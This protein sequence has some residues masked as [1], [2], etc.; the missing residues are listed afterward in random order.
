MQTTRL[1]RTGLMVSRT[2][3]GALPIQRVDFETARA[4]LTRA[5]DAGITF[6]DTASGYS[7]SE[8]KIGYALA[9]RREQVTIATKCSGAQ[10]RTQV[11]ELVQRSLERMRT[12][13]VDLLQLHNPGELPDPADPES[14]YAGLLEARERGLTRFIGITNHSRDVAEQAVKS[15]LYDTLQF[16]LS[17]ISSAEDFALAELCAQHDVGFIAM[18]AFCGGLLA[19]ARVAF[20]GLRPYEHVVPIW[21]IQRIEELEEILALE[22][23]PPSLTE[24][25]EQEIASEREALAG[26]F[27]RAC[28][29][30]LPCRVGI[31]IPIAAR[32]GLMVKRVPGERF[33]GE[34]FQTE[35]A[36]VDDCIECGDCRSRCPYHLDP[37][38]LLRSHRRRYLEWLESA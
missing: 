36:E 17:A 28:G 38:A 25:V 32:I 4:I 22:N 33:R 6:I 31:N 23:D 8:E 26:E 16:P 5:V 27:C 3:F 9:E 15:G 13:H 20:A 2:S 18:K 12:D 24:A 1:G 35:M 7:D 10:N 14:T 19:N 37:P 30:C 29:Y 21:G 34:S 11:L